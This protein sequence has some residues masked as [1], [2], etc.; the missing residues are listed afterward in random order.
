MVGRAFMIVNVLHVGQRDADV[1]G[2]ARRAPKEA[3]GPLRS[4]E[5]LAQVRGAAWSGNVR[6]LRNYIERCL[7]LRTIDPAPSGAA[8]EGDRFAV[9]ATKSYASER[10]RA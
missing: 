3:A 9:D 8:P 4:P 10:E 7:I 1:H 6:E 2:G 5:F